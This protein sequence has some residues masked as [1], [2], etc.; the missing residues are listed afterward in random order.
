[1]ADP[2]LARRGP[3]DGAVLASSADDAVRLKAVPPSSRF[4]LRGRDGLPAAANA[5]GFAL[6]IQPCRAAES[7]GLAALWLGPDEWLVIGPEHGHAD[8]PERLAAALA[9]VPHALTDVSHRNAGLVI[10]GPAAAFVLNHGCPLDLSLQ[11]FPVGMCTRTLVGRTEAVVWRTGESAF[12]LEV[13]RS[14]I[15]YLTAFLDEAR[16]EFG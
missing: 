7:G 9:G 3:L 10:S 1:M 5:L 8:L 15:P 11:A 4:V 16:R 6:P 14:F 12:H 2:V 13:W